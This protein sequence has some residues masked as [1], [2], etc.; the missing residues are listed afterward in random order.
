MPDNEPDNPGI[1]VP[2]PLIYLL[3]LLL[4]L[5]L[6]TKAHLP[7]LPNSVVRMVGWPLIGCGV[8]IGSWWRKTMRD[9]DAPVR[10]DRPVPRL[11]TAGPFGYSR[12]PAY[13]SLAMI[14]AGTAALRNSLWAMLF[15]PL[16]LYVIQREVIGRE[17]R[18]LERTFGEEYLAYKARVRRW[19]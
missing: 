3:P 10:T 19:V 13:L 5:I 16:V 18:Y 12:N 2:P 15:L 7:I 17:E 14:Y 1:K 9:A 11:T 6:H 4:G 8:L